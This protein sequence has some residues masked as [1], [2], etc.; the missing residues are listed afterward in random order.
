[1]ATAVEAVLL[2][3]KKDELALEGAS[4][5]VIDQFCRAAALNPT[6]G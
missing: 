4:I 1:M 5:V 6:A 2:I 3:S